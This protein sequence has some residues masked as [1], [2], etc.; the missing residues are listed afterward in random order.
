M[1]IRDVI[2]RLR[3]AGWVLVAT[4]GSHRQF[5][6]PTRPGRVTV[7][8]KPSDQLATGTLKSISKQSEVSLP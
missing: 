7:A 8:G 5:K 2:S 6:H 1:K 3:Q 4:R